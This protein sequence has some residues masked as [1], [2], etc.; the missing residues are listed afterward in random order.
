MHNIPNN[1]TFLKV[2][3]VTSRTND[4]T[5]PESYHNTGYYYRWSQSLTQYKGGQEK[6]REMRD[7]ADNFVKYSDL[8]WKST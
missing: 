3:F 2:F 4:R 5:I 1:E 8:K 6:T 7:E